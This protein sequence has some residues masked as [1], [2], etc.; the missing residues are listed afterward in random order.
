MPSYRDEQILV[1]SPGSETT[2]A[3]FGLAESLSP[4]SIVI[5]TR[6]YSHVGHLHEKNYFSSKGDES[7]VIYPLKAGKIVNLPAFL[8]LLKMIHKTVSQTI[9]PN[10]VSNIAVLLVSSSQW[11]RLQTETITQFIFENIQV[12]AFTIIPEA[13]AGAF[14]YGLQDLCVVDIGKDKTEITPILDFSV[15]DHARLVVN[16]G[17]SSINAQLQEKLPHLEAYQIEDLKKSDIFEILS[18]DAR[19]SSW[20]ALNETGAPEGEEEG[21]IDVAA[22][23]ASGR[24]REALA[25]KEKEKNNATKVAPSVP[26]SEKETNTFIDSKGN[27][28]EVGK[29]RFSGTEDLITAI[30]Q[31][32]GQAIYQID[33]VSRRQDCWDNIIVIGGCTGIKGM[34][35]MIYARLCEDYIVFRQST[36]SEMGSAFTS[37]RNT[38]TGTATPPVIYGGAHQG[39]H[40]QVP[41]TIKFAKMAEY[42]P[43]WKSYGWENVSFLGAQIGAKAIFSGNTDG[44]FLTLSEY[45]DVGPTS[46]WDI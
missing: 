26:N 42:F 33:E 44:T 9:L 30:V 36:Y 27:S 10:A 7:N 25:E 32:V 41:T 43:E 38:P 3:Q 1:I 46:I 17:S 45:N 22:I 39:E 12:P 8:Y 11:S 6:V 19:K 4:P 24:V 20:F 40:G 34:R 37:A 23:V 14:A 13:L 5:P 21:V 2:C 18:E 28:H 31:A 16:K 35:E 29:E 15:A